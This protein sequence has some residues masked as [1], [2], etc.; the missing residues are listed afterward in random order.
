MLWYEI[1]RVTPVLKLLIRDDE[2]HETVV[3]MVRQEITI[4]RQPGNMVR[5]TE[6][7]VSRRHARLSRQSGTFFLEDLSSANGTEVNGERLQGQVALRVGDQVRIG[8]YE[9]SIREQVAGEMPRAKGREDSSDPLQPGRPRT[10]RR[11]W[12]A[13]ALALLVLAVAITANETFFTLPAFVTRGLVKPIQA[14]ALPSSASSP[15]PAPAAQP[16]SL[17]QPT[18]ASPVIAT[19]P[20]AAPGD[21]TPPGGQVSPPITRPLEV[22]RNVREPKKTRPVKLAAVRES[23]EPEQVQQLYQQGAEQLRNND[24]NQAVSTLNR[25]LALDPTFANCHRLLGATYARLKDPE[26]GAMHYRRFIQL[27]PEDPEA[28]KVRIFL[29]QYE[30]TFGLTKKD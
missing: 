10:K 6:R 30:A 21:A 3:P 25:C 2:G 11:Q 18:P 15:A 4:G 23:S 28:A 9:L 14:I 27:A 13:G 17:D 12:L 1:E 26:Q 8:D 24:L 16:A 5:L 20:A 7:N 19:Q 22:A 29:E